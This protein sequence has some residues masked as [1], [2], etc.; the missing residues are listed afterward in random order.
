MPPREICTE[1]YLV[2]D[3]FSSKDEA[4]HL[5]RYLQTRFVRFLI[6]VYAA[7][8]QMTKDKFKS[9]PLQDFTPHSDIDWSQEV[10]EIDAQLYAKY[11]LSAE[12]ISFIERTIK[13]M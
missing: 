9:V 11:H 7:T 5:Y 10:S 2:V 1:T 13:P 6:A 4:F 8:Q 12:E 3:A